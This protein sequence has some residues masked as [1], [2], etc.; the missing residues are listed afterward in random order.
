MLL[1]RVMLG[2]NAAANYVHEKYGEYYN[3]KWIPSTY[4]FAN[5]R[6]SNN[7]IIFINFEYTQTLNDLSRLTPLTVRQNEIQYVSGNPDLKL[8][9]TFG[10]VLGYNWQINSMFSV[11]PY[12]DLRH[13]DNTVVECW[14]N[15][16]IDNIPQ[17]VKTYINNGDYNQYILAANINGQFL[18]NSLGVYL[19]PSMNWYRHTGIHDFNTSHFEITASV[20]YNISHWNF[21]ISYS[22]KQYSCNTLG[23]IHSS[24]QQ[25]SLNV[26]YSWKDLYVDLALNNIFNGS[27][28]NGTTDIKTPNYS[29]M[30]NDYGTWNH[31]NICIGLTYSIPYGRRKL[32]QSDEVS[33]SGFTITSGVLE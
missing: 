10:W 14:N 13:Y 24:P 26:G 22:T 8:R 31:R 16:F 15:S 12:F 28:N 5:Y 7:S 25:Y 11:A 32:Q 27:Y 1:N 29:Y 6:F 17:S 9:E 4:A 20:D 19:R 23:S 18:D 30:L 2:F 21:G 33:A 3:V